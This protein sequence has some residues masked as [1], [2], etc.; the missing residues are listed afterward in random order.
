MSP[1]ASGLRCI[2][3][4]SRQSNAARK[5]VEIPRA[6]QKESRWTGRAVQASPLVLAAGMGTSANLLKVL[7]K[8]APAPA[9]MLV[10]QPACCAG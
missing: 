8:S 1:H 5:I 3:T 6:Q 10:T 9:E 2:Q 7:V 4:E